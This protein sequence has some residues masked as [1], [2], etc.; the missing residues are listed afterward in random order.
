MFSIFWLN[1]FLILFYFLLH[2]NVDC[3][4]SRFK[5]DSS[6][7]PLLSQQNYDEGSSSSS[8][9]SNQQI[10]PKANN[11]KKIL[12]VT[13]VIYPHYDFFL[14][15]ANVLCYN[16]KYDVYLLVVKF[17]GNVILKKPLENV[18]LIEVTYIEDKEY[19]QVHN[20]GEFEI[21]N[22]TSEDKKDDDHLIKLLGF[23]MYFTYKGWLRN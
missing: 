21:S 16:G 13:D 7:T 9:Q 22:W 1:Y 10:P 23:Y 18:H 11:G 6:K 15:I 14:N 5:G 2:S 12:L 17:E 8:I 3:M 20:K 4:W 19:S